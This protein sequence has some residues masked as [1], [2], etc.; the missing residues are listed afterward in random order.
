M[1][2]LRDSV[3]SHKT[4]F[5]CW[6]I[7]LANVFI[8]LLE[9]A[10]PDLEIF[11][12]Q[13]ALIPKNVNFFLPSSLF[14]FLTSLFLHAGWIHLLSNMWFLKIFGDNVEATLGHFKFL[15]VYFFWGITA[16]VVQYLFLVD[17]TI[18]MLGAS[19]AIAGVLG[20]YLVFFPYSRIEVLVP[21][22]G[23]WV[24]TL[25]PAPFMLFYWF[26]T[27][28]FSGTASIVIGTAAVGGVAWWAHAGGF[29]AGYLTAKIF[30]RRRKENQVL[31]P[32]EVWL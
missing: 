29:A 15:F 23:F 30:P 18:P 26:V 6:A 9:L 28:L 4:P 2:P 7:I 13:H 21:T 24:T 17:S 5:I 1:L 19:G 16:G 8:F 14:P 31:Y 10:A 32:D 27:Q 3:R 11:I 20:A 22:F 25:V 12:S